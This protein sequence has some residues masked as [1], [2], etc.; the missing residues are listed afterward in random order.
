MI[1]DGSIQSVNPSGEP[2]SESGLHRTGLLKK[3]LMI[4]GS[5]FSRN[6]IGGAVLVEQG[7]TYVLPGGEPTKDLHKAV[8]YDLSFLRM[9]NYGSDGSPW[10]K[11]NGDKK[12]HK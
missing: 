10:S 11:N 4:Y 12:W 5:I 9:Y 1:A 2:F 6:T 3:Q 8:K 7:S